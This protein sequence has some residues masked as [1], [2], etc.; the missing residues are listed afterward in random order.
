MT[1][2]KTTRIDT[3]RAAWT[4]VL[5]VC[6]GWSLARASI[7]APP[8]DTGIEKKDLP[9]QRTEIQTI[10]RAAKIPADQAK[11]FDSYFN[12]YLLEQ[13]VKPWPG[14]PRIYSYSLDELPRL[15]QSLKNLL[16]LAKSGE[17]HDRLNALI[18]DKITSEI[19]KGNYK[20][21]DAAVK[22]NALLLLGDLNEDDEPGKPKPWA[23]PFPLLLKV[24]QSARK[25]YM[26][27]AALVG[28]ERYAAAGAIPAASMADLTKL[29]VDL[30]NQE[31]PPAGR[32]PAAHQYLRRC[33]GEILALIGS[34]GPDNSVVKALAS[35][36]AD[37]KARPTFRCEM[38][39]YLGQ[40]KYPPATKVDLQQLA[41]SLGHQAVEICKQELDAAKAASRAPD[42]RMIVYALYSAKEAVGGSDGKSGLVAA[43]AGAPAQKFV[44]SLYAKLKSLHA[45]FDGSDK[46]DD[47]DDDLVDTE[48]SAKINDL[49]G[50]LGTPDSDT[51]G[52]Q[53][54]LT[55]AERKKEAKAAAPKQ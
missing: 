28:I 9:K 49:D 48:V 17:A 10:L 14:L 27:T 43:A 36:A 34:P 13:F 19:I 46:D 50:M 40:L 22:Y 26:K 29:L 37:P 44:G 7:G 55:A 51:S 54:Q 52:K 38:A 15:R 42:R 3:G 53:E 31:D 21:H 35:V 45:K 6:F 39:Q 33:A 16:T 18:Y 32:D 8:A 12:D 30:V 20:E 1:A 5:A 25:D 24:L 47:L 4:M 41:N 2:S 11:L 23:K